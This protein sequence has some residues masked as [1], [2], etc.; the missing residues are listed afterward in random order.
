MQEQDDDKFTGGDIMHYQIEMKEIEP[1]RVAYTKYKGFAIEANKVFPNVFK[2]IRGKTNGAPLF[3]YISMDKQSKIGLIEL[4]V[5]TQ[6]RPIGNGIEVKEL[7]RMKALC[8]THLGPYESLPMAY[9]AIEAYAIENNIHLTSPFREVFIK[10]PGM[11]LK[12]KPKNYITE[13]QILILEEN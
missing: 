8:T 6:E 1:I 10:G 2:A 5:P 13:V 4:C 11:F 9:D 3:N 12:G 7:S